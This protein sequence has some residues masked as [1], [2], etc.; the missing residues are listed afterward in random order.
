MTTYTTF[1]SQLEKDPW[2]WNQSNIYNV[3]KK[4]ALRIV[5]ID[6]LVSTTVAQMTGMHWRCTTDVIHKISIAIPYLDVD[7]P[8]AA[9]S[10][11]IKADLPGDYTLAHCRMNPV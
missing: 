11:P 1:V 10:W 7:G 5:F 8:D 4:N 6:K 9:S 3:H 2:E